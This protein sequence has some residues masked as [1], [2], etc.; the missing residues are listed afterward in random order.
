MKQW[1]A[2]SSLVLF[3]STTASVVYAADTP[4]GQVIWAKGHVVATQ[5]AQS[6]RSLERR[7]PLYE[8]DVISTDGSGTGQVVFSDSS[9]V[10]LRE[11]TDF[12]IDAYAY[13]TSNGQDKSVM[14]VIKGGF[15]TITGAIPKANPAAYS[16]NTPVA[17]IGVRGTE[18]SAF[19]SSKGLLLKIDRGQ[20]DVTNQAGK[21]TM[22]PCQTISSNSCLPYVLVSNSRLAPAPLKTMPHE[23][24][25][26]PAIHAVKPAVVNSINV[27]PST[28]GNGT[29]PPPSGGNGSGGGS[30]SPSTPPKTVSGFC[31]GFLQDTFLG[32]YFC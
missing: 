18:Y 30:S 10:V 32:K 9:T 19:F 24:L 22:A 5:P 31:V 4:I 23:F 16:V 17:T 13:K 11:N 7:S 25:S 29:P 1:I 21:V 12:K 28:G 6:P 8:H 15:R 3:L 20:I 2:S 27:P 14:S 26:E